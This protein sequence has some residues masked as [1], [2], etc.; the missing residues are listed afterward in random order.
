MRQEGKT[1]WHVLCCRV[2]SY[3]VMALAFAVPTTS[4]HADIQT[5]LQWLQAQVLPSGQ[6]SNEANAIALSLQTRSEV[7]TTFEA[8]NTASSAPLLGAVE[9]A[10]TAQTVEFLARQAIAK[11]IA[12]SSADAKLSALLAMQNIDGGFGA[13]KGY[14]SNPLDTAWALLAMQPDRVSTAA[15]QNAVNWLLNNRQTNGS[16]LITADGDGIVPTALAVQALQYYRA[17]SGVS[18]AQSMARTWLTAQKKPDQ[19]W[20]SADYTAQALL[21]LLPAQTSA[22]AYSS[23][24]TQ[25]EGVQLPN[26]SWLDDSYVTALVIRA[27]WLN[28]QPVV[29]PDMSSITGVVL[30]EDTGLPM[31]GVTVSLQSN[32]QSVVTDSLGRFV[33]SQVTS[34]SD[35][36]KVQVPGYLGYTAQ[37]TIP[38]G[39]A[40]DLGALKLK[41]VTSGNV[42]TVTVTGVARFTD[43][44][45][46]YQNASNATISIGALTTQSNANGEYT[47]AGVL[48]GPSTLKA[49]YSS[50]RTVEANFAAQAGDLIRFDP[51][52]VRSS[53]GG[54]VTQNTLYVVVT[55]QQTG[56]VINTAVVNLNGIIQSVNANGET[57]FSTGVEA[58]ANTVNVTA[59]GFDTRIIGLD[60][61][62][63]QNIVLPVSLTPTSSSSGQTTL[64]GT[65][66][67]TATSFPIQG[68]IVRLNGSSHSVTTDAQGKYLIAGSP[69]FSGTQEIVV[70]RAGY[71]PHSQAIGITAGRSHTFDIPLQ[72]VPVDGQVTS[73][74]IYVTDN[75]TSQPVSGATVTLSG[76]NPYVAQ[77]DAAGLAQIG[78]I[79][80]GPTQVQV[81][82]AGYDNAVF[83]VDPKQGINYRIPVQLQ[84]QVIGT[85]RIYGRVIDAVSHQPI[86][87]A[88]VTLAGSTVLQA[89]A[90]SQGKY[91]FAGINLGRW[92]LSAMANGYMGSSTGYDFSASSEVNIP[93]R[94]GGSSSTNAGTLRTIAVGHPNYTTT[95]KGPVGYLFIFG[96]QGTTGSVMS[97]DGG[98]K[99]EFLIDSSG[100]AEIMVPNS[101][102]LSPSGQRLDKAMLVYASNPVSAYFL[103]REQYTTDMTYLLDVGALGMHYRVLDWNHSAGDI[104]MSFTAL[105]DGTTVRVTPSVALSQGN[106]QAGVPFDV[107]INKG[108][109]Y[110]YTAYSGID[111]TGTILDS[112]K[113]I[114]VFS[115]AQCSNVPTSAGYCDHLFT[116][117]PP[118]EHWADTYAV[119]KTANTGTVGNLVRIL[120]DRDGNKISINGTE[121][122]TLDAGKFYEQIV[123]EDLSISTTYPVLVGQFLKGSTV[124]TGGRLGDPAFTYIPGIRQTLSSYVFTAPTNLVPYQEN[125]VNVAISS[126]AVS[127]LRLNGL[128]V[129]TT[130]FRTIPGGNYSAGNVLVPTG[131]GEISASVPFVATLTGFNQDDSYHTLIGASY[132]SGASVLDPIIADINVATDQ[133]TYPAKTAAIMSGSIQNKGVGSA[134]LT[135]M[136]QINDADGNVVQR[137]TEQDL[138]VVQPNQVVSLQEPWNTENYPAGTYTLLGYLR[139]IDANIV[140]VSSTLFAITPGSGLNTPVGALS[141]ATDKFTYRPDDRVLIGNLVRNLTSNAMI[142]DA[143][144]ELKV[145]D[146]K[147]NTVFTQSATLGQLIAGG[148]RTLE[149]PQVLKNAPLGEYTI[150]ALLYGSGNNL[151]SARATIAKAYVTNVQLASA[152]AHYQVALAADPNPGTGGNPGGNADYAVTKTALTP[153]I[154]VGGLAA[155]EITITNNGPQDGSGVL[156]EDILPANLTNIQWTCA[157]SGQAACGTRSGSGDIKLDAT[158]YSGANDRITITVTGEA[159]LAGELNNGVSL[160]PANGSVDA[161]ISNNRSNARIS[162]GGGSAGK[163]IAPVPVNQPW[164]IVLIALLL[165]TAVNFV[166]QQKHV[167][168]D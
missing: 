29:N 163:T 155:W 33:F 45:I 16:W 76:S 77:T 118:V 159:K 109:S 108:Q 160:S 30:A 91:E 25:L 157:A 84:P 39:V 32:A 128:P 21:A 141:V 104:Q 152:T 145:T 135:A 99:T 116:Q 55:N 125:Y 72:A 57:N 1:S 136:L 82:A 138:G 6:L 78:G 53:S 142:D 62:G 93:L 35:Q 106:H 63:Q 132:S 86:P 153:S 17:Y 80:P 139:D 112:N 129:D 24:I 89:V 52:F 158:V 15:A 3:I 133:T 64:S 5:G 2:L 143:R 43:D 126:A 68:V 75:V 95:S 120:S 94:L 137:F 28:G 58:G 59:P 83:S 41:P 49:T 22:G 10:S 18:T 150:D 19:S 97:N 117:L 111:I 147:G 70:E 56:A 67:D 8:T 26:G 107:Q 9:G 38:K 88:R 131:P 119:P 90:D 96:Q 121:V 165:A 20:G 102:F 148:L 110:I 23:T 114:A 87:G 31:S 127:S 27:L 105:E 54:G 166:Q 47:L 44:G 123:A 73:F 164:V 81:T 100:V 42:T 154:A 101:Q 134:S 168:K 162:V 50:Y 34:G 167:R 115:G 7:A 60:V 103:N 151:K 4:A 46:S 98:I 65:V 85:D 13:A 130:S 14:S 48:P 12:G 36:L 156:V 122:A 61:Q 113:P 66:T 92:N 149:N 37:L 11:K 140:D 51:V 124:T 71:Q 40:V 79:N 146:P 69:D 74:Q 161:N 144:V